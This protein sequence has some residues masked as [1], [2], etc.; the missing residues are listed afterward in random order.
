L[1]IGDY[2]MPP[3]IPTVALFISLAAVLGFTGCGDST[4]AVGVSEPSIPRAVA[5]DL[6][7]RADEIANLL[8]HGDRCAAASK[9]AE[10]RRAAR[11]AIEEGSIPDALRGPLEDAVAELQ[12]I[13]CAGRTA[14]GTETSGNDTTPTSTE[15]ST[16]TTTSGTTTATTTAPETTTSETATA[17]SG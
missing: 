17:P 4:E 7:K 3:R 2:S 13:K 14:T 5:K 11:R 15:P 8:D 6:A 16:P 9:A 12:E 10:L 1:V